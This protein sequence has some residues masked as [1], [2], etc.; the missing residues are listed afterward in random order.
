MRLKGGKLL[1]DLSMF[2]LNDTFTFDLST[3]QVNCILSKGLSILIQESITEQNVCIDLIPISVRD[4][5]IDYQKISND[6]G[7]TI[8]IEL[9]YTNKKITF[10]FE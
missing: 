9:D 5:L 2:T 8:I 3:E 10:S 7:D 6:E 4:G 1:L